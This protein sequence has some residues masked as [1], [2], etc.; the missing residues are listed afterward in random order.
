MDDKPDIL[1]L[2]RIWLELRKVNATYN[3]IVRDDVGDN[4]NKENQNDDDGLDTD[5]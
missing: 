1:L 5:S 4:A 2:Q 3:A